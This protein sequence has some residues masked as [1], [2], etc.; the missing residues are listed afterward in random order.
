[1]FGKSTARLIGAGFVAAMSAGAGAQGTPPAES[2]TVYCAML[3]PACDSVLDAFQRDTGVKYAYVRLSAGEIMARVTAEKSRPQASL[4]MSGPADGYIQAAGNGLLEAYVAK[5]ADRIEAIYRDPENFWTPISIMPL[6]A[7]QNQARAAELGVDVP[8]RWED[9]ADPRYS[10]AIALADPASS[11]ASYVFLAT[12]V[13][14][15]GEDEA[16]ALL[17]KIDANVVQYTKSGGAPVQMTNLGEAALG[18]GLMQDLQN[19]LEAGYPVSVSFPEPTGYGLEAAALIAGAPQNEV[20]GAQAFLD[21]VI[22]ENGQQAVANTHRY[23]LLANVADENSAMPADV[24]IPAFIAYD[25]FWSGK[26][27]DHL[28]ARFLEE[29]RQGGRK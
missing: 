1:M 19:S 5:G 8:K 26:N 24:T 16:F 23:S 21:W 3:E 28:L 25:Q 12:L 22:S 17:K 14:G 20:A 18:T 7:I 27:R 29:V 13:Q 4:W 6:G 11:G 15:L 10:G 9:L 2:I